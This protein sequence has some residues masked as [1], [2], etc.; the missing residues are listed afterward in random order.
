ML[1]WQNSSPDKHQTTCICDT[2]YYSPSF[3]ICL[4][5][6]NCPGQSIWNSNANKCTCISPSLTMGPDG[7]VCPA[8]QVYSTITGTCQCNSQSYASQTNPLLICIAC[9]SDSIPFQN[10]CRCKP[11]YYQPVS[12]QACLRIPICVSAMAFLNMQTYQCECPN[13]YNYDPYQGCMSATC[14]INQIWSP[15]QR[16]CV[17]IL[18]I[19]IY[20]STGCIC[21]TNMVYSAATNNCVCDYRSYPVGN[22]CLPCWENSTPTIN[23][24]TC[25]CNQNYIQVGATCVKRQK[26]ISPATY[27]YNT[28]RCECNYNQLYS[29]TLGCQCSGANQVVNTLTG[30]C[31][32]NQNSYLAAS[33]SCERCW[34]NSVP[35]SNQKSC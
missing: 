31:M 22:V 8:N 15:S 29:E 26:C 18:S 33:N 35:T 24:A 32:C 27:N 30:Q 9:W 25:T 4:Q 13:G 28:N 20:S 12:Q 7:C 21:P 5:L 14:P 10:G 6:P 34:L 16:Q 3:G 23:G 1:C 19:M 2:N 17:C 11:G